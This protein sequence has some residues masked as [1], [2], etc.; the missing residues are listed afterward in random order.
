MLMLPENRFK[1]P[2]TLFLAGFACLASVWGVRDPAVAQTNWTRFR[3]VD[4]E[5]ISAQKGIPTAWSRGDYT[6]DVELPGVGHSSPIVWQDKVFI[7]SAVQEGALRFLFCL[8]AETGEEIWSRQAGYNKSHKHLKNSWASSTPATDGQ[9]VYLAFSDDEH[10]TLAAYD[11]D[12]NL[13]WRRLLGT[14]ESQHGQ[15]VSPIVFEDLVIIP[16]LQMGPSSVI[17]LDKRTGRTVWS[18][19]HSFYRTSYA[20]PVVVRLEGEK[21]QLICASGAL[22]LASL[23]PR[24]GRLNWMTGEFPEPRRTVASPVIVDGLAIQTCGGGG[25]GNVLIAVDLSDP[26][27]ASKDRIRYRREKLLPYVP[28][29]IA[30]R[31]Y[32]YLWNDNGVASCVEAASGK[33]IWTTRIGGNYS[34][35]PVCIDGKLYCQSEEGEMVVF[36][37]SPRKPE[38][39][40]VGRTRL[41]DFSHS[42]PAVAGGRLYIRTFHRLACL[43]AQR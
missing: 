17:A 3:G 27:D 8:S 18:S 7:T 10:Y 16:N 29:P 1:R 20:T 33:N 28:T 30:Y 39:E 32:L 40:D 2:R 34:G 25:V 14:F 11:F 15:G 9:R 22:G 24:S 4:G 38:P 41:G 26:D 37:A 43:E 42:T 12:G 35:S 13:V 19:V 23:D 21:P 36:P 6:W 31:G 5:G